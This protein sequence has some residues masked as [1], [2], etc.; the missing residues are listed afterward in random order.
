MIRC[1][2]DGTEAP[3]RLR[4]YFNLMALEDDASVPPG[5]PLEVIREA[6]YDGVQ[7][8][9]PVSP[10]E[11]AECEA[12]GLG[13]CGL[14]RVNRPEEADPLAA[15]LADEG[16]ECGTLHLGWGIEDD[17]EAADLIEAVIK[18]SRRRAI[19]L[20][21]ETHRA[22]LFQDM[23]RSVQL[24]DRFPEL[25]FNG[26]FSHWYTG[27]EMVYGDFAQKLAFVQPV[28]DRVRFVHG[29]IGNP[30]SMQVDIGD[31]DVERHPYVGHFR[32]L[33]RAAF[34]GFLGAAG[35]G[36]Y[37]LFV[38]ELL[39]PR[40][41]YARAWSGREE[42]ERWAQAQVLRRIARECFVEAGGG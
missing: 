26:D 6:G 13:R 14:G 12:L 9:A 7:F 20:Y 41:Y 1:T 22:T 11:I 5:R 32:E 42:C 27:Q 30:G 31:G 37:V 36:D 3:P 40:I 18:A 28:M 24:V 38:P 34:A 17:R 25:R 35:P 33:W 8:I 39:S 10:Q 29:R 2:N 16:M 21:V 15:R 4:C 23:W 19:P